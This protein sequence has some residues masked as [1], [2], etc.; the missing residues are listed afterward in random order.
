MP[1]VPYSRADA[2]LA[3]QKA[4]EG[5]TVFEVS[6]SSSPAAVRDEIE[7]AAR[8]LGVDVVVRLAPNGALIAHAERV[9]P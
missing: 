3:I 5:S 4:L 1:F 2:E 9:Q 8:A 7:A 6:E